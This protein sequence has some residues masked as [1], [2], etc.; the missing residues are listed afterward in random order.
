VLLVWIAVSRF[1]SER[2]NCLLLVKPET[3][4]DSDRRD[5]R[6]DWRLKSKVSQAR[7]K[8]I[9]AQLQPTIFRMAGENR[10]WGAPRM[11]GE[12]L[13]LGFDVSEQT[14]SRW[15]GRSPGPDLTRLR[16]AFLRNHREVIAAMDFFT[17]LA[18]EFLD[19]P[20]PCTFSMRTRVFGSHRRDIKV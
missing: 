3:V 5:F 11:R 4:V 12:L 19:A 8:A 17:V 7:R 9:S 13:M 6:T 2:K 18:P 14:I 15:M 10:T 1:W 20:G 16:L